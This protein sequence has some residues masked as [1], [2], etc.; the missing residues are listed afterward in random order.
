MEEEEEGARSFPLSPSPV[1]IHLCGRSSGGGGGQPVADVVVVVCASE[2]LT[3]MAAVSA[4]L[5]SAA[6]MAAVISRNDR[7]LAV[8]HDC[9]I[10]LTHS[11]TECLCLC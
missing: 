6:A 7:L 4:L 10:S 3:D 2:C 8:D 1:Q 9:V 5:S 11:L